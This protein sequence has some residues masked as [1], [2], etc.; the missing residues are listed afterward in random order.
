MDLI[1]AAMQD[2]ITAVRDALEKGADVNTKDNFGETALM[3]AS[4]QEHTETAKLLIEKGAD[5]NARNNGGE[6]ALMNAQRRDTQ[7]Q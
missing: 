7:K 1:E 5:V 4:G 2:N 3:Y 6:T